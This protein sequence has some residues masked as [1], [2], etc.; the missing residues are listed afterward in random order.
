MIQTTPTPQFHK[1]KIKLSEKQVNTGLQDNQFEGDQHKWRQSKSNPTSEGHRKEDQ[2][3]VEKH[4]HWLRQ[5][6]LLHMGLRHS[7][8]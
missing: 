3:I 7:H 5:R 2:F 6:Q 4:E 8:T 1:L